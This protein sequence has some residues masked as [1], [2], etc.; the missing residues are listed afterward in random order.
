MNQ[1]ELNAETGRRLKQLCKDTGISQRKLAEMI[2]RKESALSP[3]A[4][5]KATLTPRTAK[6]IHDVLPDYSVEYLTGESPYR[7][8]REREIEERKARLHNTDML[9]L[10]IGALADAC[11]YTFTARA[12]LVPQGEPLE[13]GLQKFVPDTEVIVSREGSTTTISREEMR[14]IQEEVRD[15]L[16]FKIQQAFRANSERG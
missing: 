5:G 7:N 11:G 2:G 14:R 13:S 6:Q 1:Q 8:D 12:T 4:K 10:G 9:D 15:F 3:I 16:D